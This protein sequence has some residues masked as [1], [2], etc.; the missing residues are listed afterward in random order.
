M[1]LTQI[2]FYKPFLR[3]LSVFITLRRQRYLE[4]ASCYFVWSLEIE[5]L[6]FVTYIPDQKKKKETHT[7][8]LVIFFLKTASVIIISF[9]SFERRLHHLKGMPLTARLHI[10]CF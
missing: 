2:K 5:K 6:Q 3:L 9:T 1:V 8:K 7:V 10:F 4:S